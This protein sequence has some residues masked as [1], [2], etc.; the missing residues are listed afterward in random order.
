MRE[1]LGV[2]QIYKLVCDRII[3]GDG[4]GGSPWFAV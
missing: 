4:G 2:R 1:P 3:G